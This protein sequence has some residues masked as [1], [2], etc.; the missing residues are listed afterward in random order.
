MSWWRRRWRWREHSSGRAFVEPDPEDNA[1]EAPSPAWLRKINTI[2]AALLII[3]CLLA[4]AAGIVVL[5][6]LDKI[7][8]HFN[9]TVR[10]G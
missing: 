9:K 10:H 1:A 5:E 6:N 7:I 4:L 8:E 2:I 3:I